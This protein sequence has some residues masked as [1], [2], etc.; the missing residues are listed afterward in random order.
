MTRRWIAITALL[1]ACA[2]EEAPSEPS[3]QVDVMPVLAANCVR[4]H[5]YPSVGFAPLN[6][7]LDSYD[8]VEVAGE[9]IDSIPGAANVAKDIADRTRLGPRLFDDGKL[10]MPPGRELDL[11][12]ADVLRNW[13]GIADGAGKAPRGPGRPDNASPELQVN[14]A[15]R[16]GAVV[17]LQYELRDADGDLVVGTLRGPRLDDEGNLEDGVIG[18]FVSGRD[19]MTIDLT[20]IPAGSYALVARL[21]DGADIDGPEGTADYIEISAGTL[22]VP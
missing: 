20:G 4:C 10:Q 1:A 13:A 18:G 19:T 15:A 14:E 2:A 22:E 6:L 8:D 16:D 17:T 11:Y 12:E 21:D 9:V 5:G 7:R 3:W